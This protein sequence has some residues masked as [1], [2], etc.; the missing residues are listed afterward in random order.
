MRATRWLG[1]LGLYVGAQG[2][3]LALALPFRSAGFSNGSSGSSLFAPLL[4]IAAVVVVP[5]VLLVFARR[6]N[7]LRALRALLLFAIGGALFLTLVETIYLVLPQGY[8]VMPYSAGTVIY[9]SI[10]LAASIAVVL[11]LALVMEPQW[12]VVDTAGFVAAAAVIAILGGS[13][14]ILPVFVLL[15]GLA[16]YDYIAVY[17]TK[18]MLRLADLA[19]DMKLPI[20]MVMPEEANFDY[21]SSPSLHEIRET[22]V[23]ERNALFMGLGDVVIPGVLVASAFVWLPADPAVLG[24]PASLWVALGAM[25]GS[26]IGYA[27]LMRRVLQGNAQA[28]LPFLNSGAILGYVVA[29]LLVYHSFGFG[30]T[31][32]L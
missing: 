22:P 1:L 2:L 7:L 13:F 27:F 17:R 12:Y 5:I 10:P 29:F 16:V 26:L 8:L 31:G 20:L 6:S 14:A 15:A 23:D 24:L 32:A 25:I 19:V 11:F 28:G 9:P 3:A 18:H 30:L 21:P 4:L